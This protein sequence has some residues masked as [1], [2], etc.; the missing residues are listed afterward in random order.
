MNVVGSVRGVQV[1]QLLVVVGAVKPL[2]LVNVVGS[3]RGVQTVQLVVI[4]GEVKPLAPVDGQL[5]TCSVCSQ[6]FLTFDI[7][8]ATI[9]TRLPATRKVS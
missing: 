9:T 2:A 7:C 1:V 3:V 6:L 4:V 5:A 8:S